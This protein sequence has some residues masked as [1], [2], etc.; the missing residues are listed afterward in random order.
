MQPSSLSASLSPAPS[1][2][3]SLTHSPLPPS[4]P[5]KNCRP[6]FLRSPILRLQ[7]LTSC[8]VTRLAMMLT[9]PPAC[10]LCTA[11]STTDPMP[12]QRRAMFVACTREISWTWHARHLWFVCVCAR[13]TSFVVRVCVCARADYTLCGAL[14]VGPKGTKC[15]PNTTSCLSDSTNC[16]SNTTSCLS[17]SPTRCPFGPTR[18]MIGA[19]PCFHKCLANLRHQARQAS[20]LKG[21]HSP[22]HELRRLHGIHDGTRHG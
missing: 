13:G 5:L 8:H 1:L 3:P 6:R 10:P 12:A 21:G 15:H 4:L 7:G 18:C 16:L 19:R 22:A 2:P 11:S 20:P 17:D 14:G 9:T